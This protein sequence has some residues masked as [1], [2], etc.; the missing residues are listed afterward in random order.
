MRARAI[1]HHLRQAKLLHLLDGLAV[2]V[3]RA[4]GRAVA[5]AR[6]ITAC[7]RTLRR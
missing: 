3:H 7:T 5:R 6:S 4:L 1:R 2:A